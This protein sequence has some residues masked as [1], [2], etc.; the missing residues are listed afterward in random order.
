MLA[1][2][3][4]EVDGSGGGEGCLAEIHN[5]IITGGEVGVESFA[6]GGIGA[7]GEDDGGVADGAVGIRGQADLITHTW[8]AGVEEGI[9]VEVMVDD[10][11][12]GG[13]VAR[14]S[15]DRDRRGCWCR[16]GLW[17]GAAGDQEEVKEK[18]Q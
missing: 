5:A 10:N 8:L 13:G 11:Q 14:D 4:A 3:E 18:N 12:D 6:R 1:A 17:G 7:G 16:G 9:L 2:A 15:G